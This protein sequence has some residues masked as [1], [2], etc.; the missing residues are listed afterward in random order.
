[1]LSADKNSSWLLLFF[2]WVGEVH[3]RL[4]IEMINY[5]I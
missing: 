4:L 3:A 2:G 5:S 1:M